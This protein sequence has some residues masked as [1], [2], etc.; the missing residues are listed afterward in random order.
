[1]KFRLLCILT[2]FLLLP[3]NSF[4]GSQGGAEVIHWWVSGGERAALQT[5]IDAF[6][7][8]GSKWID[9]PVESSYYAKT[10][11]ISRI[12][13]GSPPTAVLW[14][15]GVSLQQ[16]SDEG[17]VGNIDELALAEKWQE[18]LPAAIWENITVE[19][20]LIAVPLTLHGSNW[21]WA[22][23]RILDEVGIAMPQSWEEFLSQAP[24]I[25]DA[26]YIPLALGGQSWQERALFLPVVLGTG[27]VEFYEAAF[28][29]HKPEALSGPL[30]I[31][32]F[33]TFGAL[34]QFTDSEGQG[35]SWSKTTKLVI[36]GQAAFQVM[37]DWVKGEFIQAGMIPGKD[38]ICSLS[39]GS[40]GKYIIVSDALAMGKVTDVNARNMQL[41]LARTVMSPEVQ[42][43]FNLLK[44]SVPPRIDV[45]EDGFDMCAKIAMS[46]VSKAGSAYPGFNMANTGIVASAIMEVISS[47]WNNPE[48]SPEDAARMLAEA[49]VKSKM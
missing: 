32:V 23:K 46:T 48:I 13:N 18:V 41:E 11:A 33:R 12:L 37:G 29:H 3:V 6:E 40:D 1:M 36:E 42:R 24:K 21:I 44:G 14:H 15:A 39:P 20:S 49:V 19:G 8:T 22:N 35:R 10:A 28:V 27:G 2:V 43:Q 34:R 31:K 47:F 30:M 26:G 7:R 17:L 25:K 9:T 45:S 16:L 38:F 5:L 4:A